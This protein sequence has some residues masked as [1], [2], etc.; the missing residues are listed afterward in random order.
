MSSRVL[1]IADWRSEVLCLE[2][3]QP[4][5]EL[6]VLIDGVRIGRPEL[7]VAPAQLRE[8]PRRRRRD[9]RRLVGPPPRDSGQGALEDGGVFGEPVAVRSFLR[10]VES[11]GH[12]AAVVAPRAGIRADRGALHTET[13]EPEPAHPGEL[14]EHAFAQRVESQPCLELG[15]VRRPKSI[16]GG[17]E[18]L[19]RTGCRSLGFGQA[20]PIR[21]VGRPEHHEGLASA[22]FERRGGGD[23]AAKGVALRGQPG[24]VLRERGDLTLRSRD[25]LLGHG[26]GSLGAG[27]PMLRI[28]TRRIVGREARRQPV[29]TLAQIGGAGLPGGETGAGVVGRW[30]LAI[31]VGRRRGRG[32]GHAIDRLAET[33]ELAVQA[34]ALR[35]V[36]GHLPGDRL[37]F[38]GDGPFRLLGSTAV[39]GHA[40]LVSTSAIQR[41]PRLRRRRAAGRDRALQLGEL[42]L[43]AFQVGVQPSVFRP[44]FQHGI[45]GP[46]RDAGVVDDGRTVSGDRHPT[47][48]Q[49][50]LDGKACREIGQPDGAREQPPHATGGI[51]P[52]R[53][54]QPAAT[55]LGN[56]VQAAAGRRVRDRHVAREPF[57]DEQA[58][59]LGREVRDLVGPDQVGP[60]AVG[61]DGLHGRPQTRIHGEVLIQPPAA[62]LAGRP[63]DRATLLFSQVVRQGLRSTAQ[64]RDPCGSRGGPV[65]RRGPFRLRRLKR[66]P[67]RLAAREGRRLGGQRLFQ[68][69]LGRL[70]PLGDLSTTGLD[71][72][73]GRCLLCRPTF[74]LR[75]APPGRLGLRLPCGFRPTQGGELLPLCL[76]R[77]AQ[78]GQFGQRLGQLSIGLGDGRFEIEITGRHRRRHRPPLDGGFRVRG[79]T[80]VRQPRTI[81]F[82][83]LEIRRQTSVS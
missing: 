58:A 8:P 76:R 78:G 24:L 44:P 18:M 72:R 7:V 36:P 1:P 75:Q 30:P 40:G 51:S 32:H 57:L 16:V 26:R 77:G 74:R 69:L 6:S 48:G 11:I 68:G 49:R 66:R 42:H 56:G 70:V 73:R 12:R 21:V 31:R 9:R 64:P 38:S 39:R 13:R 4:R 55:G 83:R 45:C 20:G 59:A 10:R 17:A 61:K 54:D 41:D 63:C 67:G 14:H 82:D 79:G 27:S 53:L 22:R 81:P 46:E 37:R 29:A 47:R 35:L 43:G 2:G 50:C 34:R 3:V 23:F 19:A 71:G 52:D 15:V 5:L 60:R 25:P 33:R 80:L 65:G 62:G 28:E